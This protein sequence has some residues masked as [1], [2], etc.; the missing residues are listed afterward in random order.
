MWRHGVMHRRSPAAPARSVHTRVR[1]GA[2]SDPPASWRAS[3]PPTPS[4]R[5]RPPEPRDDVGRPRGGGALALPPGARTTGAT[6]LRQVGLDAGDRWPFHFVVEGD[7][8]LT[9]EGVFLHRTTRCHRTRTTLSAPRPH[10]SRSVP[11]RGHRRHHGRLG[12]PP[13]PG[14]RHG[15]AR[16]AADGGAVAPTACP[17]RRTSCRTSTGAAGRCRRLS[18]W[19]T[20]SSPDC[21]CR[22]STRRITL[23]NGTELTPD[24]L[25]RGLRPRGGVRG[26]P[27]PGG[28]AGSTTPTSTGTPPTAERRPLRAGHQGAAALTQG[29]RSADPRRAR[30]GGLRR[31]AAGLRGAWS[32]LFE[33]LAISYAVRAQRD[34]DRVHHSRRTQCG[35]DTARG[36]PACRRGR[37]AAHIAVRGSRCDTARNADAPG[38]RRGPAA[39]S[40]GASSVRQY[41]AQ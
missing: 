30:G 18:S 3:V 24:L 25:V 40:P 27:A 16:G 37:C 31:A 36:G 5:L 28:P 41:V 14:A 17:R 4:R 35:W 6:R 11:R 32:S 19:R 10:S 8:H 26:Q 21:P 13:P 2:G 20:S 7:L 1:P 38:A 29:H 15:I 39:R 34:A 22:R 33:P 23:A 12:A 9:L